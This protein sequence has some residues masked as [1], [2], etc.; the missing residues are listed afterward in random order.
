M[1]WNIRTLKRIKRTNC[2]SFVMLNHVYNILIVYY[3]IHIKIEVSSLVEIC[4]QERVPRH[5]NFRNQN[6]AVC[7]RPQSHPAAVNLDEDMSLLVATYFAGNLLR[8]ANYI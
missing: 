6:L 2:L 4:Q 8:V 5:E 3:I 7:S 1:R